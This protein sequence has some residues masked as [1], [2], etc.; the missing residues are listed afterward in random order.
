MKKKLNSLETIKML[1]IR[2]GLS[3]SQAIRKYTAMFGLP[4]KP[5]KDK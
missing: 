2:D 1:M 4:V 5:R 3:V